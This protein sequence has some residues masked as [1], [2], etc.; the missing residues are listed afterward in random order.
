MLAVE[1]VRMTEAPSTSSGSAFLHGEQHTLHVPTERVV[2]LL[3][4]DAPE[5]QVR[6]A[7][8]IGEQDV[9]PAGIGFHLRIKP[10]EVGHFRG[11]GLD[12]C[13]IPANVGDGLVE[14]GLTAP[15]DEHAGT[16]RRKALRAGKADACGATGNDGDFPCE[17]PCHDLSPDG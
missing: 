1:P 14:R 4:C 15:G 17:S 9:D 12:A 6:A 7:T 5:R 8:C 2:I 3:F 16:F 11:V 13:R 10:I